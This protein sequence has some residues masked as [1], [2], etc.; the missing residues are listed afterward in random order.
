MKPSTADM[1]RAYLMTVSLATTLIIAFVLVANF[2]LGISDDAFQ[3]ALFRLSAA[4][5]II[6]LVLVTKWAAR[7]AFQAAIFNHQ[8]TLEDSGSQ[9]IA[10][11]RECPRRALVVLHL[12]FT[13]KSGDL[14]IS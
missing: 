2:F 1:L 8:V 4:S 6:F 11:T 5:S 3:S 10:L 13:R 9:R 12:R 14:I 7:R